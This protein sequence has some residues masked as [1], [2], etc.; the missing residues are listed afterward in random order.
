MEGSFLETLPMGVRPLVGK[1]M[2]EHLVPPDEL[3]RELKSHEQQ[4]DRAAAGRGDL[5]VHLAECIGRSCVVLLD[6]LRP[7]TPEE[8]RR[9]VQLACRYLV[10]TEDEKGDLGSVFGFDDDAEVLNAVVMKLGR[11]DLVVSV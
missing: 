1:L 8:S 7:D 5:D 6:A 9:L 10:E 11:P 3:R 2:R 4:V